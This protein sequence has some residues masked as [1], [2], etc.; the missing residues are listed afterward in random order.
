VW[1][2]DEMMWVDE[3][4]KGR[5]KVLGLIRGGLANMEFPPTSVKHHACL[6]ITHMTRC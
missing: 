5:E 2:E 3:S 4:E 1:T 6:L